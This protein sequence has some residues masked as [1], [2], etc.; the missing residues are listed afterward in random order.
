MTLS[1][2]DKLDREVETE[3][4][5]LD[6][7]MKHGVCDISLLKKMLSERVIRGVTSDMINTNMLNKIA[8]NAHG[9]WFRK[10][11]NDPSIDKVMLYNHVFI[12]LDM[13]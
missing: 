11:L 2:N 9:G 10:S 12:M 7:F 1:T 4:F 6:C 8:Y 13:Y 3:K 5:L